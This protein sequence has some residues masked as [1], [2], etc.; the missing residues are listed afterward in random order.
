MGGESAGCLT[1]KGHCEQEFFFWGGEKGGLGEKGGALG[2]HLIRL[3]PATTSRY[4]IRS[5]LRQ[6]EMDQL[7]AFPRPTVNR[8]EVR[9]CALWQTF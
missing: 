3:S 1:G 7:M 6:P 9:T 8:L 2:R 4:S 5:R